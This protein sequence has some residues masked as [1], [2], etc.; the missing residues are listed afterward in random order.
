MIKK[1]SFTLLLLSILIALATSN[2]HINIKYRNVFNGREKLSKDIAKEIYQ[3]F[4]S[5]YHEKT[6][7]RFSL[8]M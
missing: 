4:H 5:K 3:E 8:F 2:S 7:Y 1:I 6:E